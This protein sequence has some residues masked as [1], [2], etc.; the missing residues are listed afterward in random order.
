MR[1]K[2]LEKLKAFKSIDVVLEEKRESCQGDHLFI[3]DHGS[4]I[5]DQDCVDEQCFVPSTVN[6]NS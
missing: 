4:D 3:L 6:I 2:P 1:I 5:A